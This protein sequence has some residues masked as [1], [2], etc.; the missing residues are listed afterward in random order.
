[1]ITWVKGSSR[2]ASLKRRTWLREPRNIRPRVSIHGPGRLILLFL[3]S[4]LCCCYCRCRCCCSFWC[5][6]LHRYLTHI[7]GDLVVTW[8][9]VWNFET[10]QRVLRIILL[11]LLIYAIIFMNH[12]SEWVLSNS[13]SRVKWRNETIRAR[14]CDSPFS[15]GHASLSHA[16]DPTE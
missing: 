4:S 13:N 10:C 7:V 14:T 9:F 12:D 3:L 15:R 16:R 11:R 5:P 8:Q 1:M 2:C 6:M